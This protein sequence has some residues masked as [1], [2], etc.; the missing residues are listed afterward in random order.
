MVPAPL[1]LTRAA[2]LISLLSRTAS[3]L[4][5][6]FRQF[7][8]VFEVER[9]HDLW[10]QP[11]KVAITGFLSRGRMGR[12]QDATQLAAI[13]GEPADIAAVRRYTSRGGISLN[14]EQ[15][16]LPDLGFFARA[17]LATDNVRSEERRVGKAGRA[18]R[19]QYAA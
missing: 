1:D 8:L 13:T 2:S 15:Q 10:G 12:Y 19:R 5:P 17:G 16:L 11:G 7:Q 4:D 3:Q 14:V 18:R 9:R 6:G